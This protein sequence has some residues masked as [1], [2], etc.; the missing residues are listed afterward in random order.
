MA[1]GKEKENKGKEREKNLLGGGVR[2]VKTQKYENEQYTA[3]E[4][5]KVKEFSE[6]KC[7]FQ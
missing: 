2:R 1:E 6:N 3:K 4:S 5:K 7:L